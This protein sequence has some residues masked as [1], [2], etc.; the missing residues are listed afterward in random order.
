VRPRLFPLVVLLAI[1]CAFAQKNSAKNPSTDDNSV[2]DPALLQFLQNSPFQHGAFH[3]YEDGFQA[4]DI[5][6]H[7]QRPEPEDFKKVKEYRVA[8]RGYEDGDKDEYRTGYQDGYIL[9]Y[10]DAEAGHAFAGF[11][12]LQAAAAHR[13]V[14]VAQDDPA[15][16]DDTADRLEIATLKAPLHVP[17]DAVFSAKQTAQPPGPSRDTILARIMNNLRRTFMPTLASPQAVVGAT[18]SGFTGQDAARVNQR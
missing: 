7:L 14:T 6:F 4:G 15:V 10:K 16:S 11:E 2:T 12:R 1:A 9:G 5:D 3:G 18:A 8:T 17:V 13:P